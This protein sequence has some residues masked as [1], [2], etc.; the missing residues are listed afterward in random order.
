MRWGPAAR[1]SLRGVDD[2]GMACALVTGLTEEGRAHLEKRRLRRAVRIVTVAAVLG[3]RLVLPEKRSAVLGMA[4]RAGLVDRV[5]HELRRRGR[6]VRRMAGR[7]SHLA[8]AQRMMRELVEVRVLRLMTAGAD[9]D[10]GRRRLHRILGRVQLM[11]ARARDIACGVCTRGPIV[12]RVRLMADRDIARSVGRGCLRLGTEIDH[13]RQRTA[14]CRHMRTPRPVAGL[15]LQAAVTERAARI[16]GPG[17]LGAKDARDARI[18]VT[19][20]AGVRALRAV[21]GCRR[22][23]RGRRACRRRARG[24]RARS[25]SSGRRGRRVIRG[26]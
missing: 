11:A 15:A 4:A 26:E 9:L 14:S 23:A 3:D 5:L 12:R 21:G 1:Q 22:R 2:R 10:L 16:V 18:V 24:R 13:A 20:Q 17:V 7:A 8:L 25:A 6:A 19:A